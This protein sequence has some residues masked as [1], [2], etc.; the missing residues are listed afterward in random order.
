MKM[1]RLDV[2]GSHGYTIHSVASLLVLDRNEISQ[3]VSWMQ[4]QRAWRWRRGWKCLFVFPVTCLWR[5]STLA[6]RQSLI[7]LAWIR[8]PGIDPNTAIRPCRQSRGP[9]WLPPRVAVRQMSAVTRLSRQCYCS[10]T[11]SARLSL[12]SARRVRSLT[13]PVLCG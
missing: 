2:A 8:C 5:L 7:V 11:E 4:R 3:C 9:S 12:A 6:R 10:H 1:F 13:I